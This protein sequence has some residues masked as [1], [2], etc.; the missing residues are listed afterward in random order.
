M[1]NS[2][3]KI[4][5]FTKP[6]P[7]IIF[8]NFFDKYFFYE[9]EKNFPSV[10]NLKKANGKVGRFDYDISYQSDLY[11]NLIQNSAYKKLHNYIHSKSFINFF[12]SFFKEDLLNEFKKKNLAINIKKI[13]KVDFPVEGIKSTNIY[14]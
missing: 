3:F 1:I 2:N 5:K 7:F 6:F 10:D 8:E 4:K 12:I 13:K 14:N 9:L 11:K